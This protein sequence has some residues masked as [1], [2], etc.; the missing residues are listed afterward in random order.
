MLYITLCCILYAI[1]TT[2]ATYTTCCIKISN[3]LLISDCDSTHSMCSRP[4]LISLEAQN[5]LLRRSRQFIVDFPRTPSSVSQTI[6]CL[7]FSK[8]VVY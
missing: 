7:L 4:S 6:L 1:D 8:L 5:T 2:H 3:P